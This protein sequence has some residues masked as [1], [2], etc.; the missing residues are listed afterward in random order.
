MKIYQ[1]KYD[2]TEQYRLHKN[3][4]YEKYKDSEVLKGCLFYPVDHISEALEMML[5]D[6]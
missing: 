1:N 4:L 3:E 2:L 6:L 5:V